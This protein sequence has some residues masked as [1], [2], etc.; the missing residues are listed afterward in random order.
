[1][2]HLTQKLD[3]RRL[4]L[5]KS[6]QAAPKYQVLKQHLIDELRAGHLKPGQA[7]P[8]EEGLARSLAVARTTVRQALG[9][10]E[11]DGLVDRIQGTGTFIHKQA[12][13]RLRNGLDAFALVVPATREGYYP[14]LL[15]TF[16]AES[17]K[18]HNQMIVCCSEND[19]DKQSSALMQ[20]LDMKPAGVAIVPA[21]C[22]PTPA[23][24]IRQLRDAH[25]PVVFCYR[26]VN[27]ISAPLLTIPFCEVGRVAGRALLE[28][29][30]RRVALLASQHSD[31]TEAYRTGLE[32]VLRA[33]G[34]DL[35]PQLVHFDDGHHRKIAEKRKWMRPV[36]ERM[37]LGS[38]PPSAIMTDFDP[39]TELAYLLL[40]ELGLKVPEDISLIGFGGTWREGAMLEKLAAVTVDTGELG[41]RAVKLL[42][43]MRR[44]GR[45]LDDS[46]EFV[47]PLA[48]AMGGTL[49]PARKQRAEGFDRPGGNGNG[50]Q[51]TQPQALSCR[52]GSRAQ[53]EKPFIEH[54]NLV[55]LEVISKH[56]LKSPTVGQ[57]LRPLKN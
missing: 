46:E 25:I 41:R 52:H 17:R 47:M 8:S 49:G 54:N 14:S 22:A 29:G 11:Q 20:L 6:S 43:E 2:D 13:E 56:L 19:L 5:S 50:E 26:G 33:G 10:L 30:H 45:P 39:Q 21:P 37:F 7:L 48:L 38:D 28:Q 1:M 32:E 44:G 23:Y 16:E 35:P 34:G 55:T 42:C 51:I 27:D 31:A 40:Q 4:D 57:M 15:K 53:T 9:E 3:L 12:R 36:L 18:S 24:Q